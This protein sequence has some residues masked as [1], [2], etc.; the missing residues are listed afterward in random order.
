MENPL[1]VFISSIIA[2]MSAERQAAPE[3]IGGMPIA[4]C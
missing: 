1:V 2:G 4:S 3:S